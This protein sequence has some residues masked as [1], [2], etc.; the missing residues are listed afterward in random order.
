MGGLLHSGRVLLA[1]RLRQ[2][3]DRI[4]PRPQAGPEAQAAPAVEADVDPSAVG[5][6][7]AVLMP[8][9]AQVTVEAPD[10]GSA[11]GRGRLTAALAEHGS[12]RAA[13]RALAIGESTLRCRLR[14]H[15]IEAPRSR[16]GRRAGAARAA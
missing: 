6:P 8:A 13:A 5:E 11:D 9:A 3:A 15:G 12:I 2:A 7:V 14:R 10:Q 16:R 4:D 1:E